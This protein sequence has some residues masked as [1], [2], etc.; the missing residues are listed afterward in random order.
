[1]PELFSIQEAKEARIDGMYIIFLNELWIGSKLTKFG[2]RAEEVHVIQAD[3]C[4]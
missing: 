2:G 1:M 3:G 4:I